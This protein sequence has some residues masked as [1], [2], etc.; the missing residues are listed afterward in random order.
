MNITINIL[1]VASEL[2]HK[3]VARHFN[4]DA[5]KIYE[6]VGDSETKYTENAQSIFDE[7]YDYFY[8]F[9]EN[10]KE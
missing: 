10:L 4:Y 7:Q 5:T 9:L 8:E 3:E 6:W 1:E 2:A